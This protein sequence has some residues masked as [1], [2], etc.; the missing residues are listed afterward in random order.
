IR[1]YANI[2]KGPKVQEALAAGAQI[3]GGEEIV[4]DILEGTFKFG[5]IDRCI[6]TT[7]MLPSVLK[8]AKILGPRQLMP[9][10]KKG[11]VTDDIAGTIKEMTGKFE[12]RND[13]S[14]II[15]A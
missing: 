13:R 1:N 9:T 3:V 6:S 2:N 11:T 14:G 4:T 10:I 5:E 12:F 8:I 15:H 7:D